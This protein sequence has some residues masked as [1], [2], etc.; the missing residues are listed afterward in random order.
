[1]GLIV[2]LFL[3]EKKHLLL[4]YVSLLGIIVISRRILRLYSLRDY[5]HLNQFTL[6]NT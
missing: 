2:A 5:G 1:M 6:R 3:L 4:Q